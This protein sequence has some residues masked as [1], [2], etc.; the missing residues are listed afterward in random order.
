MTLKCV[1]YTLGVGVVY[2]TLL[3]TSASAP[4]VLV[5]P[6][7][8]YDF[9]HEYNNFVRSYFG[10]PKDTTQVSQET[11]RVNAGILDLKQYD[12]TRRLASKLFNF[13]DDPKRD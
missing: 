2:L 9:T 8:L 3:P 13:T 4:L 10:C 12:K 1:A 11:C 6:E 5:D 7:V